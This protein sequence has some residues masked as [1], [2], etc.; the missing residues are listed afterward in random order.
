MTSCQ[1]LIGYDSTSKT[2]ALTV[3]TPS[4]N[5]QMTVNGVD[6]ERQIN[7]ISDAIPGVTFNLKAK[8]TADET[9][10][11]TRS[12]D[13]SKKVIT[14]WVKAYNALQSTIA[15]VTKYV[16]VDPGTAQ[17]GSNGALVGDST[18]RGIQADVR[19]MLT[20]VQSGSYA[21]M[22]QLGITQD[23]VLAPDGS[24]QLKVDDTKLTQALTDNPQGVINYFAGDGKT[25]GFATQLDTKLNNM[26]ST[27]S[28]NSGVIKNAQDGINSTLKTIGDRRQAMSDS[29]DATMARYKTQFTSLASLVS[30]MTNMGNY[31]A[32]Q[33]NK[34]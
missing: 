7:S 28:I 12:T 15:T 19:S 20:N 31:L 16:K 5:A 29:I 3:Q 14:D 21:I 9:L 30:S 32:Q 2:G 4:Q 10:S 18:V 13:A 8:S 25:T 24:S 33:F 1:A 34:S 22:A 6:I 17:D 27:S 26:L 23:P 11:V